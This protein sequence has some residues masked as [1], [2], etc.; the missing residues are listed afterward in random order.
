MSGVGGYSRTAGR[1]LTPRM[2]AVLDAAGRGLT[3]GQTARELGVSEA[4]VWSIRTAAC[5]RLGNA[6]NVV[7]AYARARARG[8]LA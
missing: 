8:E 1:P 3:A 5:M 2:V 7:A 4:T 6:P